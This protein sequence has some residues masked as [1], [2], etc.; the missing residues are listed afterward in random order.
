MPKNAPRPADRDLAELAADPANPRVISN[1]ALAGL[2][3]SIDDF[4]D[5]SG[6]T[7]N[8]RTGQLVTGHQ[9]VT[10]LGL[11]GAKVWVANETSGTIVHPITGNAFVI[12]IVDWDERMQ[13]LANLVAN[14]PAVAGT[15]T[16][17]ALDQLRALEE[18]AAFTA[19]R[20]DALMETIAEEHPNHGGRARGRPGRRGRR[21]GAA[22]RADH[23]PGRP[24]DPRRAPAAVRIVD[25]RR[26]H[27]EAAG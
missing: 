27:R 7:W 23:P 9:R 14:N 24:V 6:I 16:V 10:A 18:D 20:L 17:D 25:G 4:G 13:R 19:L 15:F 8:K 3:Q 26:G 1:E 2:R 22:G 21:A 11:A 12:R 5:L